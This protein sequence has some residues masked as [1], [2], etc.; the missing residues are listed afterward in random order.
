MVYIEINGVRLDQQILLAITEAVV[1]HGF[2]AALFLT[3]HLPWLRPKAHWTNSRWLGP[4]KF[5]LTTYSIFALITEALWVQIASLTKIDTDENGFV[6]IWS[7]EHLAV[8][9]LVQASA[10]LAVLMTWTYS[11]R[12]PVAQTLRGITSA[13]AMIMMAITMAGMYESG[14]CGAMIFPMLTSSLGMTMGCLC[15]PWHMGAWDM[16][17][18]PTEA[19]IRDSDEERI[20]YTS[21]GWWCVSRQRSRERRRLQQTPYETLTRLERRKKKLADT[22]LSRLNGYEEDSSSEEEDVDQDLGDSDS[23]FMTEMDKSDSEAHQLVPVSPPPSSPRPPG[24]SDPIVDD[25][26]PPTQSLLVDDPN[27]WTNK[28]RKG[29]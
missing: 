3:V 10:L 23:P 29:E 4:W 25:D 28:N 24:S 20:G 9:A 16:H 21:I 12:V 19:V 1:A 18:P 2:V 11:R 8:W 6:C 7:Q 17:P 15:L 26:P 27:G 14:P 22:A 13:H 5:Y